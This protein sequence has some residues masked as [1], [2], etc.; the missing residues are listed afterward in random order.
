MAGWVRFFGSG[1]LESCAPPAM[2]RK[3]HFP[4]QEINTRER[5][6]RYFARRNI[7]GTS[8]E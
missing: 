2:R 3:D 7:E 8:P 1:A 4:L 6:Q 5:E